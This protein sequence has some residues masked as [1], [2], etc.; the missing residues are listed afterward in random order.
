M[1]IIVSGD[2]SM[3]EPGRNH[4]APPT[5]FSFPSP[6]PPPPSSL[7]FSTTTTIVPEI[8]ATFTIMSWKWPSASIARR[9]RASSSF[10]V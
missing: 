7:S 1:R 9:A 10:S 8:C 3:L 2:G 5:I 4:N 6:P